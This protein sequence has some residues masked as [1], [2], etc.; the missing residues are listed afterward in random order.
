MLV[1]NQ[2]SEDSV[3]AYAQAQAAEASEARL[4]VM[5]LERRLRILERQLDTIHSSWTWRI[6][7]VVLFPVTL[8]RWSRGKVLRS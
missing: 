6:G 2:L 8:V 5:F 1:V 3:L 7:R 4:K